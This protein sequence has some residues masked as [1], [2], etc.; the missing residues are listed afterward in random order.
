VGVLAILAAACGGGETATTLF[1]ADD[2]AEAQVVDDEVLTVATLIVADLGDDAGLDA[3]LLAFE[4]G[5]SIDQ[6]LTI[7]SNGR[8]LDG[9]GMIT[10]PAGVVDPEVGSLGLIELPDGPTAMGGPVGVLAVYRSSEI[11]AGEAPIAGLRVD[12]ETSDIEDLRTHAQA[13]ARLGDSPAEV[14]AAIEAGAVGLIL[15]WAVNGYSGEQII[16]ALALGGRHSLVP[17][18]RGINYCILLM[19][20]DEP[21]IPASRPLRR[22]ACLDE[23]SDMYGNSQSAS[24]EAAT[25]TTTETTAPSTAAGDYTFSAAVTD[26]YVW[27]GSFSIVGGEL[28]G[29]GTVTGAVDD[30][31]GIE[32]GI[33]HPVAYSLSGTY[34]ITGSAD[35]STMFIIL[36]PTG[37]NVDLTAGDTSELCVEITVDVAE[38]LVAF[39]LGDVDVGG[40]PIEVP[41]GGGS[42]ALDY[43]FVIEVTVSTN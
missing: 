18:R 25:T 43:G 19:V 40:L 7:G 17:G 23:L 20:G 12:I 21:I 37:G 13:L 16:E 24:A 27:A 42:T 39:P 29:S 26:I 3:L 35:E 2:D 38:E 33:R 34:D 6:L 9:L 36:R 11:V 8:A 30:T 1:S 5:Y 14:R 4:R 31:C 15:T 10:G 32:G 22:P 41:I 28:V